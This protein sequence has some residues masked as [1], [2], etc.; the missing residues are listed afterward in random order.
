MKCKWEAQLKSHIFGEVF[1]I[2]FQWELEKVQRVGP[3]LQ[4]NWCNYCNWY[5]LTQLMQPVNR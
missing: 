2:H 3:Q 4:C 1:I 5:F